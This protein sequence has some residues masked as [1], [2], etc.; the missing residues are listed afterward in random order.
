LCTTI[1]G[2]DGFEYTASIERIKAPHGL[3]S[4]AIYSTWDQTKEPAAERRV[5]QLNLDA[6]G[7]RA[8]R[9]LIDGALAEVLQWT[10]AAS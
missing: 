2:V 1:T 3:H 8:L 10:A 6:D 4:L 9:E 7:L 5:V